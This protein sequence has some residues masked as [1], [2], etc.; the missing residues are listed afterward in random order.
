ML[1]A[2]QRMDL[3]SYTDIFN[4]LAQLG[5]LVVFLMQGCGIYSFIY[6][7]AATLLIGPAFL[8]W[9]CHRLGFLPPAGKWGR[10][11]WKMFKGIF[12]YGKDVFLFNLGAQLQ[13]A[14][15]TIVV[16]RFLGL[17]QAALWSVGT[18]VFNLMVPVI[19]RPNG[20]ALPGMYE[21]LTRSEIDQLKS[22]FRGMV[23]LTA[24]LGAYLS[25][26]FA[27]CNHLFIEI[28]T[29]GKIIWLPI[30]DILLGFWL[31]II[32]L[33]TTHCCFVTV[34]KQIGNMRY[35]LFIEGCSFIGL[36]SMFGYRWGITGMIATSIFCTLIFSYQYSL[37]R[38]RDFF[39]C[40]LT[41]LAVCWV[42]PSLKLA[43]VFTTI[44]V[45]VSF[46]DAGLPTIWRLVIHVVVAVVAGGTLFI[47]IGFPTEMIREA[48]LRLPRSAG[49]LLQLVV[50]KI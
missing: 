23:L 10:A 14:S 1:Y 37:R 45:A 3:Q 27:L 49:R 44:A 24:S 47:R 31:F 7:N 48:A 26:S 19:C 13:M 18:K 6:A 36:V 25:V 20:A 30:N 39:S 28:W 17:E 15:Q 9:N 2:H 22:R 50:L 16:S 38:S 4:L 41:E 8:F 42:V 11:S 12:N 35:I 34:T 46:L 21:M 29:S 32:S 5:L 33:T 43:M 40:S